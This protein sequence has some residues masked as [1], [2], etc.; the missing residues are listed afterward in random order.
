MTDNTIR[1]Y[2]AMQAG[3]ALQPYQFDAGELHP[4][5]VEVQVE[6]CGLCHSDVSV[7]NNEWNSSVYPVVAGH[8]IIGTIS[9]LGSEAKGLKL[10]QRVGIGWTAESCQHCDPWVSGQ[11]V[12]CTGGP[13]ATIDGHAGGFADK[14]RAGWQWI[15]PLPEE[16][17]P[18]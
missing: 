10:G 16:R 4:H 14:V 3:A 6:Y 11:H 17:E 13:T 18:E 1:A 8:E 5:Q 7:I 15:I 9:R 12:L 2:A